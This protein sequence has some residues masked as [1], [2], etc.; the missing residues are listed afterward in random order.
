MLLIV[1]VL[2]LSYK[3]WDLHRRFEQV[4]DMAAMLSLTLHSVQS[5]IPGGHL[6]NAKGLAK[7]SLE[8]SREM[9]IKL[10][11]SGEGWDLF[12]YFSNKQ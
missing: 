5:E 3:L 8:A 11:L 6:Q 12:D 7:E 4:N 9:K 2:T 10:Q 1:V